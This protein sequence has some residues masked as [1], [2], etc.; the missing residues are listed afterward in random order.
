[1][2][3]IQSSR[4]FNCCCF[5]SLFGDYCSFP[6]CSYCL[7][8]QAQTQNLWYNYHSNASRQQGDGKTKQA[9][10]NSKSFRNFDLLES[11]CWRSLIW[12]Q[13]LSLKLC[14]WQ[15]LCIVYMI[16]VDYQLLNHCSITAY[17]VCSVFKLYRFGWHRLL[18]CLCMCF[19]MILS[20]LSS[21]PLPVRWHF[22]PLLHSLRT[23]SCSRLKF[24]I[25]FC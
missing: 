13:L 17:N 9:S 10:K 23:F 20:V 8:T 5:F 14:I 2:R 7:R 1:M 3:T 24:G 19:I 18:L 21:F 12:H 6:L 4:C 25:R 15:F 16:I 22:F 11:V